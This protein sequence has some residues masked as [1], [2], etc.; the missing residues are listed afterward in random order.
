L[1][2]QRRLAQHTLNPK[3]LA[4]HAARVLLGT[5]GEPARAAR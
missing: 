3:F 1:Q 2:D 5:F 4:D